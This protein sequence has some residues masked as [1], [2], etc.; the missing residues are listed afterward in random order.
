MGGL[1]LELDFEYGVVFDFVPVVFPASSN[2]LVCA[3]AFF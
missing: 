3:A 1:L 2:L